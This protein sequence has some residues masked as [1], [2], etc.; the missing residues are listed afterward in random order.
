[1]RTHNRLGDENADAGV[2]DKLLPS[3]SRRGQVE[4]LRVQS[5]CVPVCP[6]WPAATVGI[7]I[8]AGKPRIANQ[9]VTEMYIDLFDLCVVSLSLKDVS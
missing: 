6:S 3:T 5:G 4:S 7:D 9:A 1:M 8:V 2:A